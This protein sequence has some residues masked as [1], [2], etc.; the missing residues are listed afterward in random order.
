[1][2]LEE[3]GWYKIVLPAGAGEELNIIFNNGGN[4]KQTNDMK[5]TDMKYRFFL[6]NGIA[7]QKYGTKKEALAAIASGDDVSY[8]TVYFYNENADDDA[9]QNVAL[10]VYGGENG[11]YNNLIGGWPGKSMDRE[12]GTNWYSVAVPSAAIETH[13]LT[14][15]FNNNGGGSQLADNKDITREKSYFTSSSTDSFSSKEEVLKYLGISTEEPGDDPQDPGTEDPQEP[16]DDPEEPGTDEP[17][18]EPDEPVVEPEEPVVEPEEPVIEPEEPEEPQEPESPFKPCLPPVPP[19]QIIIPVMR[20]IRRIVAIF[21]S[22]I[23]R[24]CW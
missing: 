22:S 4:G 19:I 1:M 3:D 14:Y 7:Y 15:I 5:I 6:H 24:F 16:G 18:V 9:W 8:T 21:I 20:M 12:E 10:Y 2:T 13:T 17:V 23:F 11:E